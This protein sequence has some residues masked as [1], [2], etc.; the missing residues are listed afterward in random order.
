MKNILKWFSALALLV[1]G[2]FV[3]VSCGDDDDDVPAPA[4]K[5]QVSDLESEI[6][7][8]SWYVV[9]QN[10][11]KRVEITVMNFGQNGQGMIAEGHAEAEKNWEIKYDEAQMTYALDGNHIKMNIQTERGV[12]VYEGDVYVYTDGTA[13]VRIV[14]N[15]QNKTMALYRLAQGNTGRQVLEQLVAKKNNNGGGNGDEASVVGTW[16]ITYC[17]EG[18]YVGETLTLNSNGTANFS[19]VK[20]TL[21][22]QKDKNQYGNTIINIY[23]GSER[24]SQIIISFVQKGNVM[25]GCFFDEDYDDYGITLT[26][27]GYTVPSNG[28]LG[29]W[30]V[31]SVNFEGPEVGDVLV[32]GDGNE[33]YIEGDEDTIG[34]QLGTVTNNRATLSIIMEEGTMPGSLTINNWQTVTWLSNGNTLSLRKL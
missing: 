15:G 33:L 28:I 20:E 7:G 22:Y 19:P 3:F 23:N 30:E 31:T 13:E 27:S 1:M 34:Y 12:V 18:S 32:F 17:E 11:D 2:A 5:T 6:V 21:T 16:N 8:K 4:P 26:K 9:P 29:R 24:V 10:T 25:N 14:E